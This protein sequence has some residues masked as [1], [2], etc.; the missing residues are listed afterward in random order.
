MELVGPAKGRCEVITI[1]R[2]EAIF[3]CGSGIA[4]LPTGCGPSG[5]ERILFHF[6]SEST[7]P[8]PNPGPR[9]I[10]LFGYTACASPS[11]YFSVFF[12]QILGRPDFLT[13]V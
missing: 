11:L 6:L 5:R 10:N 7:V 4:K 8:F 9:L 12:R 1:G 13:W 2:R 3:R